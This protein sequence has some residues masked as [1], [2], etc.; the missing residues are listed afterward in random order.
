MHVG[1]SQLCCERNDLDAALTH[2]LISRELGEHAGLPQNRYRWRVAM[3]RIRAAEGNPGAALDLL[4]QAQDLYVGDFSPE[5]RPVA[6]LRARLRVA[7]GTWA[8]ALSWAQQ[9]GLDTKDELSYLREFEHITLARVLLARY[10]DERDERTVDEATRLLERL[11]SAADQGNRTGSIIDVL[12]VRAKARQLQGDLPAAIASLC[13]A[14]TLAEPEGYVR[15]FVDEGPSM[16]ALLRTVEK[17]GDGGSYVRRILAAFGGT[18]EGSAHTRQDLVDPLSARELDVLRLLG[19]DLDGPD[20]ARELVVSLNTVR[21]HTKNIYAKLGVNNRR[22]AVRR[23]DELD[24]MSRGRDRRSAR[25]V[26]RDR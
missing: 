8:E 17:Q 25:T 26:V 16:A 5:V 22:A 13:R 21:T 6:A 10:A 3:A 20:I 7:Q 19:T 9:R 18:M 12:V 23:A 2:L 1:M 24:L 4:D 14:L 15:I 11:L